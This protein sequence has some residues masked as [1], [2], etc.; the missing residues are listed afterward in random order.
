MITDKMNSS[1]DTQYLTLVSKIL[2]KID[3]GVAKDR[4]G[5]G[6]YRLF[7]HQMRF[8]LRE[9]FPL[10]SLKKTHFSSVVKELAWFL[11][12]STNIGDLGCSIWNEW[13]YEGTNKEIPNGTI[14]PM[15]GEQW[16]RKVGITHP[17]GALSVEDQL[18]NIL[19]EA[20]RNH[21][22]SRLI[23]NTWDANKLPRPYLS[24]QDNLDQGYMAL[25]PCHFAYQF[26]CEEIDGV[27]YMDIKVHLRSQDV[28]LG[29]PFN[30][31]SYALLLMLSANY[32]G[33]VARDLI[34][35]MGDCHIYGNHL[36][37]ADQFMHQAKT[38]LA[39]VASD[40][41]D[42]TWK[43]VKLNI[44]SHF[45]PFNLDEKD[46]EGITN[47]EKVIN[48]LENYNPSAAIKFPRN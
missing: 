20:K 34:S 27:V 9:E 17:R 40:K 15:Y 46:E 6:R 10:L 12:G 30:I 43:P 28:F 21:T 14:G 4:T 26:F 18:T 7:N 29:T 1:I 23:V 5:A 36:E 35:D 31:A 24:V 47:L 33:Y 2:S 42:G 48:S 3:N 8:D 16:R 25:A 11:R 22:S 13:A 39:K 41:H 38:H 19:H 32:C 45:T 44:P 37:G